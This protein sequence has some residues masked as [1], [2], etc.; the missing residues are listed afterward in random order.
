MNNLFGLTTNP[1]NRSLT[2]GGSSG[3]EAALIAFGGSP[4]GVGSDIGGSLRIPAACCGLFTL[5]PSFGRF[6]TLWTRSGLAG[7]EAV[8]SVNG[9]LAR[10][11]QDLRIYCKAVVEGGPWLEDPRCLPIPWRDAKVK[12]RLKIGVMWNDGVVI[13]T[14]PVRRALKETVEKLKKAGHELV[15]WK[16]DGHAEGLKI[17]VGLGFS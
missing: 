14:P 4:L 15:D 9:P 3:G 2:S 7:Q 10:T 5:R 6:P 13:P 11:L 17:M 16:P 12:T 1:L 8:Q